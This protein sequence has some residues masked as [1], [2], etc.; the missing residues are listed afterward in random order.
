MIRR[1]SG[2]LV[3]FC[4]ALA[5]A[6][7]AGPRVAAA[8][9]RSAGAAFV[10]AEP[11]T[12]LEHFFGQMS[13]STN[14]YFGRASLPADTAGLDSALQAGLAHPP[15]R[16]VARGRWLRYD[17]GPTLR[18]N[19]VE[20]GVFGAAA[21]VGWR[22][23][24]GRLRGDLAYATG[25][26]AGIGGVGWERRTGTDERQWLAEAYGGRRTDVMD[27]GRHED[28]DDPLSSLAA[29]W[30]GSDTR[31]LVSRS[32]VSVSLARNTPMWRLSAGWRD[33]I[34]SGLGVTTT[35]NLLHRPLASPDNVRATHGRVSEA[36]YTG[37]IRTPG[38]P[39]YGEIEY[40]TARKV[41]GSD[42]S[43]RLLRVGAGADLGVGRWSALAPQLLYGRL[44][45]DA[46]PQESF[47][48]DRTSVLTTR[49]SDPIAGTRIALARLDWIGTRDLL[50]LAHLPHPAMF[51]LQ[52]D[53]F[54]A[55]G[56]VWGQDPYGGAA[57]P[58]GN[59]PERGEWSSEAG[60]ALA[61]QPGVPEPT[62][63]L[64]LSLAWPL[65]ERP[66]RGKLTVTFTR[67][68][69]LIQVPGYE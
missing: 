6:G 14:R 61:W 63:L 19:R 15:K 35:W 39:V 25:P 46:L 23:S 34:E 64:R 1:R 45:G 47:Y 17:W 42:F 28:V 13:D 52:G 22:R 33:E 41:L 31:Q 30:H 49:L 53:L 16:R 18:F 48:L 27:R 24:Y 20:G 10:A 36:M 67:A 21:T 9:A 56:T 29:A 26:R 50:E 2:A 38:V 66:K 11:D 43:Y 3:P 54:A 7:A 57:R 69:T 65:D 40:R 51:P 68:L 4:A 44:T 59:W 62:S 8:D 60:V 55:S 58:G 5:L 32:G 12:S 37:W